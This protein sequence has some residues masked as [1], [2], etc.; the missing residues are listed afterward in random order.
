MFFFANN[1]FKY[2]LSL[3]WAGTLVS[4]AWTAGCG[5]RTYELNFLHFLFQLLVFRLVLDV[6]GACSDAD[7]VRL[8]LLAGRGRGEGYLVV[9]LLVVWRRGGLARHGARPGGGRRL[10]MDKSRKGV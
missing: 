5:C 8:C 6:F 9:H 4:E 3:S 7:D 2:S 10:M 1:N